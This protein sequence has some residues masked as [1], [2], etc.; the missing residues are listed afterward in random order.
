MAT[1]SRDDV[2]GIREDIDGLIAAIKPHGPSWRLLQT[3]PTSKHHL[4]TLTIASSSLLSPG[5]FDR[6]FILPRLCASDEDTSIT[7]E[8]LTSTVVSA[9]ALVIDIHTIAK[10]H[11]NLG[12]WDL[13]E[14]FYL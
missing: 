1:R 8:N 11:K 3:I 2:P 13:G 7:V 10:I 6:N 4:S 14:D 9:H 12:T 5:N